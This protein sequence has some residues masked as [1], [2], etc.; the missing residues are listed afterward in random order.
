MMWIFK[1]LSSLRLTLV[2][3]VLSL[4]L[5]FLGTMAQE[6]LGLYL[7]QRRFFQSAFVD[8]ASFVAASKKALQMVHIY[9]APSTAADVLAAPWV[10]VFPG[11]YLLGS[12]LLINL[13]A[14][15]ISR[16]RLSPKK[17]GI[18]L[19]H[20]GLIILLIGQ[21]F[22]DILAKE[23]AMR[24]TEGQTKSY[25]ESD[26]RTELAIVDVSAPDKDRVVA[27]PDSALRTGEVI[28]HPDL[29]FSIKV[30][31]FYPNSYI[32]N[33][34]AVPDAPPVSSK[35]PGS[36]FAA[37]ELPVVTAMDM[38]DVPSAVIEFVGAKGSLASYL[39]T[40]YFGQ[41]QTFEL[42]Q[43][44][45]EI[46]LRPRRQYL[47]FS[48]TLMDFRHDKYT[49]TEIPKNF[50]SQV[51]LQNPRT[52]EDREVLIYM[53]NPLRYKGLTF[54]QASFDKT[55]DRVTI[56]QVV[57]NPAWL[58]P[59]FACIIV[60]VGLVIQFLIHLTGFIRRQ[61]SGSAAGAVKIA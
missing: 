61:P 34:P 49:G 60:G 18:L 29:P 58:T 19:A 44:V 47:D 43:R 9:M 8:L 42:D 31:R 1:P 15:H 17:A 59:Y 10:P 41:P 40:E 37:V 2:L 28:Q 26:R 11:G 5:V 55:D 32:T 39:V 20:A 7:A 12:L 52:G 50:S 27:I 54:Y 23:S 57:R 13:T 53:N 22:T 14:A 56:L 30:V 3:L 6:P 33:R 36:R 35:G 48:L 4:V 38:R 21:L 16:F 46:N 24:L 51:R 45:F 25:S